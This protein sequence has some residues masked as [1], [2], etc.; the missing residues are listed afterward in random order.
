MLGGAIDFVIG[1]TRQK[2]LKDRLE[3]WWL[4]LSYVR[5]R[6]LGRE[7]ALFAVQVMDR[8][9]GS[10]LFSPRRVLVAIMSAFAFGG[11][12]IVLVL[13]SSVAEF[14]WWN[15][16]DAVH[17]VW[18]VI[19]LFFFATSFSIT[20]IAAIVV[21]RFLYISPFFSLFGLLFLLCFQYLLFCYWDFAFS[22]LILQLVML[23]QIFASVFHSSL[24]SLRLS[25]IFSLLI[26]HT[27]STFHFTY[28]MASN[29]FYI[30]PT[31]QLTKIGRLFTP[32]NSDVSPSSFMLHLSGLLSLV[33]NLTRLSL[34]LI[35]VVSLLLQPLRR[36]IMIF[37]ARV[38]ENEK[39]VFTVAL[40][41]LFSGGAALYEIAGHIVSG[42]CV[43]HL[44]GY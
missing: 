19:I 41:L 29:G 23:Q 38:I 27:I 32:Y 20:R 4:R 2:R 37:W 5:W 1:P 18:L 17:F 33:P 30:L 15:F 6:N 43:I 13:L 31:W 34:M 11:L 39:P 35:F 8:L 10:R 12:I 9:F 44:N 14:Q 28:A 3:T 7:E 21:A 22:S 36:S 42:G 24:T 16:F 40:P 26:W 25:D